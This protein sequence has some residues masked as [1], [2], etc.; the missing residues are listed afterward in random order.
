MK[1]L[2]INNLHRK[3]G[4]ADVVYFNTAKLLEA[5]G[6][7]VCFF[8][9]KTGDMESVGDTSLFAPSQD[10][11]GFIG[12][13]R[14]Y[15]YNKSAATSIQKVIDVYHPDIA[16]V[17]LIWGGLS[18]SI[19][20][21][22]QCN[23]IPV[24]HSVHDY[25]MICPA[26]TFRSIDGRIC[27]KCKGGKYYKCVLKRCSKGSLAQS[28]LM[29]FEMYN[30]NRKY[31]P[32]NLIDGFVF[33][34]EFARQ[35]HLEFNSAFKRVPSIVL[36]NFWSGDRPDF[37]TSVTKSDSYYLYYGRLS[38][39]KG[40][41]T[42]FSAFS[43]RPDLLLKVVGDGPEREE[44]VNYCQLNKVS[45]IEF[46][47]YKT[48]NELFDIVSG[49]RFVC[50]PSEWYENNPM[51]I[52]ESYALGTPVIGAKIG[53]IPEIIEVGKTGYVFES[54]NVNELVDLLVKTSQISN[55]EYDDMRKSVCAFADQKFSKEEHLKELV[56]FYEMIIKNKVN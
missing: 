29:A 22:L 16:H 11:E 6:H 48:G 28:V 1:V 52:I 5:N 37:S 9:I 30:R 47:G 21:V 51:T 44:L 24:V 27:E 12:R 23:H 35:K 19:L 31:S 17:H 34:S 45:N 3:R 41:H 36:Y 7:E 40:I 46:L 53:G 10:K 8:S 15:C 2:L 56:A 39:E 33:V 38:R 55:S 54:G 14:D 43:K 50:V 42:L 32:T 18:P 25:R 20:E 26:Y 49:A 13:V 4:G